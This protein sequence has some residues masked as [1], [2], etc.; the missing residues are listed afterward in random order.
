MVLG[1]GKESDDKD[2][3]QWTQAAEELEQQ[4]R[5]IRF[6]APESLGVAF[7]GKWKL[8]ENDCPLTNDQLDNICGWFLGMQTDD[9][10]LKPELIQL[11]RVFTESIR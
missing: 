4:V 10:G 5:L 9:R 2:G 11:G 8:K 1:L 7:F 3:Y 6:M